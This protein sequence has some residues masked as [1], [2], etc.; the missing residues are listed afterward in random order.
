M[1]RT[2]GTDARSSLEVATRAVIG[3][4]RLGRRKIR[5]RRGNNVRVFHILMSPFIVG[6]GP[7]HATRACERVPLA[8]VRARQRSRGTGPRD[9]K[10]NGAIRKK[11]PPRN[12]GRGPV[13]RHATIAGETRS[14]AR[15][16]SEGPRATKKTARYKKNA[17]RNVG[18]G[19]VPRHATIAG[20]TR[21]HARMAS[22]GPRATKKTARYKKNATRNVGRGPVP[23]HAT[24]AGETRS[25]ARMASEG[26]RATKKTARY[27]KKRH[28]AT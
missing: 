27:K 28:P 12:V 21:S 10:K 13:P 18:R 7:S 5:Y 24:I 15:M 23:R 20:E 3:C 8:I 22:E 26:P 1:R 19:P 2:V 16:A 4:M 14:H 9:T 11:T 17:T 25:H 6:C